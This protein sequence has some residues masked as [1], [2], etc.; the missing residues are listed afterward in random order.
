VEATLVLP[1]YYTGLTDT[2]TVRRED[3]QPVRYSLDRRFQLPLTLK[4]RAKSWTWLV[5]E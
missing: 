4:M 2:A 3:G 1:L 5:I